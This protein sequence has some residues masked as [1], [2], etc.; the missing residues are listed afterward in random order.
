MKWRN[1]GSANQVWLDTHGQHNY[2]IPLVG[3]KKK[4][5]AAHPQKSVNGCCLPK[6]T[7]TAAC[8]FYG[9]LSTMSKKAPIVPDSSTEDIYPGTSSYTSEPLFAYQK[10]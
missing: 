8:L 4:C 9:M 2:F 10:R 7:P 5:L 6:G 1:P 3:L